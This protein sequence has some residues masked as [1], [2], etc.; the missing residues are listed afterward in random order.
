MSNFLSSAL[1][2]AD[3]TTLV[4]RLETA[5]SR[6]WLDER[7]G[8]GSFSFSIPYEDATELTT[9]RIVK[10][11]WGTT[12]TTY[13]FAGVIESVTVS[14]TGGDVQGENRVAS[15]SGRG[16]RCLLENALV[17]PAGGSSTR[18]FNS[19]S[20]GKIMRTLL[21]EA[22]ARGALLELSADFS[23]TIDSNGAAFSKSLT[24]SESAGTN[25]SEIAARHQELAVDIYVSPDMEIRYYNNRGA[26]LTVATPTVSL[27]VGQSVGELSTE[28]AGPVRNTVLVAYGSNAF[29]TRSNSGSVGTYGR[30]ETY[31]NLSS[32][33]A[34]ATH[35]NLAGDQ[36]LSVSAVPSDGI[37]VQ[38]DTSGPQPYEDF[39]VGDY[40]W[41]VD[42]TAT[43]SKYRVSSITATEG[44]DGSVTFV[45]E[46][47]TLRAD[48]TR[49]LNRALSRLEAKNAGGASTVDL[50]P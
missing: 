49:R 27:R 10:L 22:H 28:K 42:H 21:T 36:V 18:T 12:N 40:L 5:Y 50:T 45:P 16:V 32:N 17:Y 47:G 38:I 13:V 26:D 7:D 24:L 37:T 39:N 46:L 35:A 1:F 29:V 9:G 34:S 30:K 15:V 3:G 4:R 44:E 11:S 20:A 48:L 25:L 19:V 23:D 43:R 14:K 41:V 6:Q 8:E 31:L 2:E 33:T